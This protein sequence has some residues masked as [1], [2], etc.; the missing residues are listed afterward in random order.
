MQFTFVSDTSDEAFLLD[1][2]S[3]A[4]VGASAKVS[5]A[6][7]HLRTRTSRRK[8]QAGRRTEAEGTGSGFLISSDGYLVTNC[9]VVQ[10]AQG[11]QVDLPD[12][13]RAE[14]EIVGQDPATDLALLRIELDN[15]PTARFGNSALLRVGQL[16]LAIGNPFGF[17]STVTAG[18]VSALGRSLRSQNGR[19]I[20][21]V[22]QTDAALNPG[23]SGGPLVNSRG[24]VVGINTAIIRPGQGLC[25]AV[26]SNTAD[27][28]VGALIH[29]GR[30]RRGYLGIAGQQ[31][32]LSAHFR[33]ETDLE[34]GIL[35]QQVEPDAPNYNREIKPGD[36]IISFDGK[37]VRGIDDLHRLLDEASI[38]SR[39]SLE[40]IR[41][42][43]RMYITVV[44]GELL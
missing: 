10:A 27:F 43:T 16:V 11:I 9:H 2:Y 23:N 19:L 44:P 7:V 20:D 14:A 1:A 17:E 40:I 13:R 32:R 25:F 22:I 41:Q 26:A 36:I 38:G 42:E 29:K 12:G 31:V 37:P 3:E 34:K 21:N 30:V 15:L 5:P 28:V 18:V 39:I 6:V 24:E 33:Q 8:N 4:V 35:V